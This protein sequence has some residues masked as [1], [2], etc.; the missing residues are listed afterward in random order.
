MTTVGFGADANDVVRSAQ[1]AQEAIER[2]DWSVAELSLTE[3]QDWVGRLL[4]E[5]GGK[6]REQLQAPPPDEGDRG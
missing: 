1:Q 5:V 2:E 6:V 4:R 3:V